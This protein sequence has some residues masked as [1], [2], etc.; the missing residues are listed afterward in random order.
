MN[1]LFN[2]HAYVP[3]WNAG[4][5]KSFHDLAK[6][7]KAQGHDVRIIVP[8]I[9]DYEYEG[10]RV[11]KEHRYDNE[12]LWRQADLVFTQLNMTGM[13]RNVSR[14]YGKPLVH[15]ARNDISYD[16]VRYAGPGNYIVYNSNW[17]AKS[18]NYPI[19]GYVLPPSVDYRYY[20]VG[21]DPFSRKYITLINHNENKGANQVIEI[22]RKMPERQFLFVDG[23]YGDQI[24]ADLPNLTVWPHQTDIRE[25]YKA[26]RILLMPS[27]YESWG[28]TCTE[29]MC[30][31]I[32]VIHSDT[33]GLN[34]NTA[35]MQIPAD[36]AYTVEWIK[37]ISM[38]D[39][40]G[41]YSEFSTNG[42]ARAKELD[43]EVQLTKFVQWLEMIVK[44]KEVA[45]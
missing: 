25:V 33:K 32:P 18:L 14:Y 5:E 2:I 27:N 12:R 31:G 26:T 43:P 40:E 34:E 28:R 3:H 29:A 38:L 20:D 13:S 36:R 22:A 39:K 41:I 10:I 1:I 37:N 8:F 6:G 4:A 7:L 24:T 21:G 16:M 19:P 44:R 17:V 30:N 42:R 35:G 11:H 23:G 45:A 15:F 9:K